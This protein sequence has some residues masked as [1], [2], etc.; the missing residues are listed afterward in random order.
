VWCVKDERKVRGK[1]SEKR[2]KGEREQGE[3]RADVDCKE[4]EKREGEESQK[5]AK[6]EV[7]EWKE[8]EKRGRR[9]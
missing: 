9:E 7:E 5:R 6:G 1:E 4:I 2:V 3:R 8:T